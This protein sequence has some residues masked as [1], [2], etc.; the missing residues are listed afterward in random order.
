MN[1]IDASILHPDAEYLSAFDLRL[2]YRYHRMLMPYLTTHIVEIFREVLF[3]PLQV[4]RRSD[5]DLVIMD[6][7]HRWMAAIMMAGMREDMLVPCDIHEGLTLPEEALMFGRFN[8]CDW[9]QED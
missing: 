3:G 6:G 4:N 1:K 7:G 2:D 8:G 9:A 5:G